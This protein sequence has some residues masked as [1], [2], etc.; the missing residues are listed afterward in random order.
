MRLATLRSMYEPYVYALSQ[1]L[2]LELPEWMAT[3]G[4]YDDGIQRLGFIL[5]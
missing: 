5:R 4:N 2:L 1:K 3:E